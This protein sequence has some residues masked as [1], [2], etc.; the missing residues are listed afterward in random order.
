M[1]AGRRGALALLMVAQFFYAWGW[2]T[3][4]V[5]RPQVQ[6]ALG[7]TLPQAGA[8]YSAQVIGTVLGAWLLSHL[9]RRS[10]TAVA[11][12]VMMA[13]GGVCGVPSGIT[14]SAMGSFTARPP[15]RSC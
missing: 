7:L 1:R 5:L 10:G 8:G 6:H 9:A 4:D 2:S 12:A 14:W 3:A 11:M 13:G 15:R